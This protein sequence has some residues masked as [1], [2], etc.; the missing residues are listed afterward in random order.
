MSDYRDETV[1]SELDRFLDGELS[2]EEFEKWVYD[3]PGIE[4]ALG[5]SRYLDLVS[6][7]FDQRHALHD[8]SSLVA[9]IYDEARPGLLAR[10][11]AR[12]LARGLLDGGIDLAAA[13]RGLATLHNDGNEWIPIVFVGIDSELDEVP[14]ESQYPLWEPN[15]LQARLREL[16]PFIEQWR[17]TACSAAREL[18]GFELGQH[19]A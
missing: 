11:R 2:L 15:A 17:E 3:N 16:Q 6:F 8:L 1:W 12:R 18:L 5:S 19:G 9:S 14:Q 10:D 7:E 4:R 13:V